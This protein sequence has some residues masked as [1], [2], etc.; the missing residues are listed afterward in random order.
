MLVSPSALC[1]AMAWA[2]GLAVLGLLVAPGCAHAPAQAEVPPPGPALPLPRSSI[3]AVLFHQGDLDLSADQVQRLQ[4]RDDELDRTQRALREDFAH[5]QQAH[6]A[7]PAPPPSPGPGGG[8]RHHGQSRPLPEAKPAV[9]SL[10]DRLDDNDSR[11]YLAAEADILSEKQRDHARE[12]ASKY[13]E[14]LYDQRE[15]SRAQGK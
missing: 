12:V 4:A 5:A 11:A 3:A 2:S 6:E 10:D 14:D 15:Q 7:A 9:K 13:R 8:G 1:S